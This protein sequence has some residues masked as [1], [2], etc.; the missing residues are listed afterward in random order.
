MY[1]FHVSDMSGNRN[2]EPKERIHKRWMG[3]LLL[4]GVIFAG[5]AFMFARLF[6]SMAAPDLSVWQSI[7][8]SFG[9]SLFS[10][11][12]I[13]IIEPNIRRGFKTAVKQ[14]SVEVKDELL[15]EVEETVN[16]KFD[17]IKQEIQASMQS[18]MDS[19]D[20]VVA[21]FQ[22]AYSQ[23]SARAAMELMANIGGLEDSKISISGSAE[24]GDLVVFLS[25][26]YVPDESGY[27]EPPYTSIQEYS[28]CLGASME[29]GEG[30]VTWPPSDSF[31]DAIQN[32]CSELES[33]GVLGSAQARNY[34]WDD[35]GGRLASGL[36]VALDS[37]RKTFGK[38]HLAG[39]LS[40]VIGIDNPWYI[41]AESLENP[42]HDFLARAK[43]FP[44]RQVGMDGNGVTFP[45]AFK[46]PESAN[47]NEWKYALRVATDKFSPVMLVGHPF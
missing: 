4:T 30:W 19:Q 21:D 5:S 31:A 15:T 41:T 43:E 35:V 38:I 8:A 9:V 13:L 32:L 1:C 33:A 18:K 3:L 47:D 11:G 24:P 42:T 22:S 45:D 26:Q 29:T 2:Q 7:A 28:L 10:A 17:S 34:D 14:A 39:P 16:V 6:P 23:Q 20:A 25:L 12:L 46:R 36:Q 40:H 44:R 37:R 27:E